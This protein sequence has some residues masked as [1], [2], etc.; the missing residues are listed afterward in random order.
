MLVVVEVALGVVGD[1][2]LVGAG[3]NGDHAGNEV[4]ELEGVASGAKEEVEAVVGLPDA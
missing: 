4:H 3:S 2:L 1:E